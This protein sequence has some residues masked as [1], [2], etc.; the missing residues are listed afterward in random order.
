MVRLH[1]CRARGVTHDMDMSH[2][3]IVPVVLDFT[4]SLA[5][6]CLPEDVAD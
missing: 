5:I 6:V 4:S 1:A 2:S 3:A